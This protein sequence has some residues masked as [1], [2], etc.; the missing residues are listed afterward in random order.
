MVNDD[1]PVVVGVPLK[2]PVLALSDSQDGRLPELT[3]NV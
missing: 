2:T 1:E 3:E